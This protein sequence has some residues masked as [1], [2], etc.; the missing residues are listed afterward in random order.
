MFDFILQSKK[1]GKDQEY[2]NL[3]QNAKL[4]LFFKQNEVQTGICFPDKKVIL[5]FW[6]EHGAWYRQ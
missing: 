6:K 1:E 2:N 5:M 4:A 3:F